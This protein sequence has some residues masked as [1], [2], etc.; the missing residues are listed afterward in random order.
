MFFPLFW[1]SPLSGF[2]RYCQAKQCHLAV[3]FTVIVYISSVA[4]SWLLVAS[5]RQQ[6]G[7]QRAVCKTRS[8]S[9][10]NTWHENFPE[11]YMR[12][13]YLNF[14]NQREL[15]QLSVSKPHQ[16][17]KRSLCVSFL[18]SQVLSSTYLGLSPSI[19]RY[20]LANVRGQRWH[21]SAS[22]TLPGISGALTSVTV[23][24]WKMAAYGFLSAIQGGAVE[25]SQSQGCAHLD[26]QT[27]Q[28]TSMEPIVIGSSK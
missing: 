24:G 6:V 19:R 22:F 8:M 28:N 13:A 5:A 17:L 10:G 23:V 12:Q 3:I 9:V 27:R 7:W 15:K 2:S 14:F 4:K 1:S 25:A 21:W 26:S 11:N 18:L 16:H 20:M